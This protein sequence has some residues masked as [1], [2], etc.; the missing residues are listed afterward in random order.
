MKEIKQKTIAKLVIAS[1]IARVAMKPDK[2]QT[3]TIDK[4]QTTRRK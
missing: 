1:G 3:A 2:N 4:K